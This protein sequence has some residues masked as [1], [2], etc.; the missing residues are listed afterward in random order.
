MCNFSIRVAKYIYFLNQ[1][2]L[3][4]HFVRKKI[5]FLSLESKTCLS[6][7]RNMLE[8][9]FWDFSFIFDLGALT[10]FSKK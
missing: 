6:H 7:Y 10:F 5:E 4:C 9:K 2:L 3:F 1:K 8:D